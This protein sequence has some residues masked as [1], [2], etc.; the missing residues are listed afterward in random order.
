MP[1]GGIA[2]GTIWLD[3]QSRLRVWQIFN[4]HS[5]PAIPASFFA[6]RAKVG[7]AAPVVRALQTVAE[8][9]FPALPSLTFEGG[10]PVARLDYETGLPLAVSLEAFNPMIP[11]DTPNSSLPCAIFRYTVRNTGTEPADVTLGG[12]LQNA[13]WY[14]GGA[15]IDGVAC[16]LY[17]RNVTSLVRE[18]GL[19]ALAMTARAEPPPPGFLR[20]R[21]GKDPLTDTVPVLYIERLDSPEA[22]ANASPGAVAAVVALAGLA[23]RA[24]IV[25]VAGST[26]PFFDLLPKARDLAKGWDALEVFEDFER[27]NYE[28]WTIEGDAFG[29]GPSH[30]T[31]ANQNPVSGF[32]G[33]G[34]VNTFRPNDTPKGRLI[35][36]E[37]SIKKPFIGFLVGGGSHPNET[38]I[39]LV[40]D[41][42][43]VRTA[44]GRNSEQL[45]PHTWD[46]RD[47]RGRKARIEIVDQNTGGWGH[48]N[49]DHIVMADAPPDSLMGLIQ[50]LGAI[51][52]LLGLRYGGVEKVTPPGGAEVTRT[53]ELASDERLPRW[54][55]ASYVK[56][57]GL[58]APGGVR[59]LAK[60]ASG[61]PIVLLVPIGSSRLILSLA[62]DMPW[63][64]SQALTR[65]AAGLSSDVVF[66]TTYPGWGSM[67]LATP[68]GSASADAGWTDAEALAERLR[69]TG[70]VSGSRRAGPSEAGSTHNGAL[71]V[72]F[73][74]APGEERAVPFV[75]AWHFP[76]VERFGHTGNHYCEQHEDALAVARYVVGNLRALTEKTLLYRQSVYES[77]IPEEFLDAM[78]SQ[79]VI[80]RGP[81]C[82]RSADG[83]FG[84]FEG[85]YGCCPLNCSHVWNYAQTHGRLFPEIG[86]NIR[87]SDFVTWL[88]PDGET[89]HRHL[90]N[91]GAFA[92]GHCASIEA[93][94]REHQMSLDDDFLHSVY[95]GV[96]KAMDWF[97]AR[98]DK[99]EEGLTRSHQWNTYDTAVSGLNTFIGS[100]YLSALGAAETM[101]RAMGDAFSAGRWRA[102]RERG[103]AAQND[104]LWNGRYYFQIP[105]T[106]PA[107]DYDNG[108]H[109]DQ[110]LG[111]WWAHQIGLGYLYPASRVKQAM[112][113]VFGNNFHADF[114][115]LPQIPRR[116]IDDG[117]GGLYMCT[118][119]GNDR[120]EPYTLYSIEAWTGVEYSTAG[121][122]VYE[123]LLDEAR[124]I[125]RTARK[126]YDGR[127]RRNLDSGYG[128]CGAGNPFQEL[129]CGKFYAR[130]QSSWSL[131][132]ACQGLVLDGPSGL[133]G[134]RPNWQPADHRSFFTVPEGWGLF[135][136]TRPAAGLQVERVEL[137]HG[138]LQ[139][140]RMVFA[141]PAGA[142]VQ[143]CTVLVGAAEVLAETE[144][145]DAGD[146]LIRF[147]DEVELSGG[148]ALEVR[149]EL[150]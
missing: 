91:T 79:S 20:A 123:G 102:I 30:G 139:L 7:E 47:L 146:L 3:G 84:G 90:P 52:P 28:G 10:Y 144:T 74:L 127:P 126:R 72:S 35:S 53:E 5:E 2:T 145:G 114:A 87:V 75:I 132:I 18:D 86:R 98:F 9:G 71:G 45:L 120:P 137:R 76:N 11:T 77:N 69:L 31:E 138:K 80:L 51:G 50:P 60:T 32:L 34:L 111:Q 107:N 29:A 131:L 97:I 41:G 124:A 55:A 103:M 117:D 43:V 113:E 93:A 23:D 134:F 104:K 21:S 57:E 149:L 81:T 59:V 33:Q 38:C 148:D 67:C 150:A 63:E 105:E 56:L 109:S 122:M 12:S 130:A 19:T 95:P 112:R 64:W 17:G 133:L 54:L 36:R 46:V 101:A 65:A 135:T 125:V 110:L 39:N 118:W 115:G 73:H 40:V 6:L 42:S 26:K 92:D 82:W 85:A 61:D 128:V 49:V 147:R 4:N 14:D 58:A 96:R 108:C 66:E 8:P 25:V 116:Y 141:V 37:F 89:S 1:I 68:E 62:A 22:M 119:P 129:E 140:R 121:L 99:A 100:Q 24:G 94:L 106:P 83:Y 78:T 142:R 136:Q 16:P 143:S 44:G 13:V 70:S 27:P 88:H 48:I 15:A